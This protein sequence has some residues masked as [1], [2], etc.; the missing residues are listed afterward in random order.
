MVLA[1]AI[2][3]LISSVGVVDLAWT[4]RVLSETRDTAHDVLV[5]VTGVSPPRRP[6]RLH[7]SVKAA[8]ILA[9]ILAYGYIGYSSRPADKA[10]PQAD[11]DEHQAAFVPPLSAQF[12]IGGVGLRFGPPAGY[13]LYPAP[14]MQSVIMRQGQINP[15]NVVH[16][17]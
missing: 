15:D 13:C 12:D 4:L 16:T 5:P 7:W 10:N 3:T 6:I 9:T 1:A 8:I 11:A 14:L 2:G 17:A